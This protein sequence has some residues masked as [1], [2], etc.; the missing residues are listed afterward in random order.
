MWGVGRL[1][2]SSKR[3]E[4]HVPGII[5]LLL[6]FFLGGLRWHLLSGLPELPLKQRL[7][8]LLAGEA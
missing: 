4:T 3:K 8:L 7:L 5:D 1:K 6:S 2:T